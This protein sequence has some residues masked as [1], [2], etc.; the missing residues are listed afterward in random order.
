MR[1]I[2][3]VDDD[4]FVRSMVV[5][6]L[7][8]AGYNVSEASDGEQGIKACGA[9][10]PDVVITDIFMPHQDGIDVLRHLKSGSGARPRVLVI[11]GGSPRMRGMDYLEVAKKL[12]A[13]AVV[14]KPFAPQDLI[15]AVEGVNE[16]VDSNAT[17]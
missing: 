11:S 16:K 15:D 5:R 9:L 7:Q 8:R 13:D 6:V 14:Q 4:E 12:G 10:S 3:V 17:E 2:L 1:N